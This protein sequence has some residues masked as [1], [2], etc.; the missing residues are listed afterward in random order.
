MFENDEPTLTANKV[1]FN[2][3]SP[4]VEEEVVDPK[5]KK[6]PKGI[7]KKDSPFTEEEEAQY[8]PKKVFLECKSDVEPKEVRFSMQIVY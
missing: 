4:E 7:V 2:L 3:I 8:G 6:D 5:A 1:L